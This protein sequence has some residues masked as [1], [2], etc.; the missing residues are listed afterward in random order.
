M[1]TDLAS[2]VVDTTLALRKSHPDAP[3]IA[4]LDLVMRGR[5]DLWLGDLLKLMVPPEPFALLVAEALGD[6]S[7]TAE[8][9]ALT[10]PNSTPEVREAMRQSYLA[11]VLVRFSR[12]Y[13][14]CWPFTDRELMTA[15]CKHWVATR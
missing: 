12:R 7:P 9:L 6:S 10:G 14:F 3:A 2:K 5:G 4:I 11:T 15:V 8:W 1:T 13:G